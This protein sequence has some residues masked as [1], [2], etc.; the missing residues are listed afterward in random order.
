[1]KKFLSVLLAI[2]IIFSLSVFASAEGNDFRVSDAVIVVGKNAVSTDLYAAQ[3]LEYYLEKITGEDIAVVTD[4]A[5]VNAKEFIV[6]E[7]NRTTVD[8]E[9]PKNGSYVIK[10][11]DNKLI[12][13]GYGTRGTIYGVYAFLEDFC[14]CRWYETNIIKIPENA[15]LA[16]G[17]GL[18]VK[19]TPYFEYTETDTT[20]SRDPE[21]S[22]AN[23]QNGGV[24]R[25]L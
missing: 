21:F 9:N 2:T 11:D 12:I 4:D 8:F 13:A 17:N 1:M 25:Y 22:I 6:G 24:Y 23:G 16:V 3:K 7:T 20:S 5:E 15:D 18:D 10:S 19:Y 14:G